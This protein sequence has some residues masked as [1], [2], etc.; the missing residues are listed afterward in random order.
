MSVATAIK[1]SPNNSMGR[2]SSINSDRARNNHS[3]TSKNSRSNNH[4]TP[5]NNARSET[6]HHSA[7]SNSVRNRMCASNMRNNPGVMSA[8]NNHSANNIGCYRH[9]ASSSVCNR[10]GT[11]SRCETG[12]QSGGRVLSYSAPSKSVV[13]RK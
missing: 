3:S 6:T 1:A 13:I 10:S 4:G 8:C 2:L 11:S 9:S 12:N 5:S 7:F